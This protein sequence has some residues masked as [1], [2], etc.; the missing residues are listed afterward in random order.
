MKYQ[1]KLPVSGR[2][3][4]ETII[5]SPIGYKNREIEIYLPPNYCCLKDRYKVCFITNSGK[6]VYGPFGNGDIFDFS[7]ISDKKIKVKAILNKEYNIQIR[8]R[9][10]TVI[11]ANGELSPFEITYDYTGLID[12][13]ACK[14]A[15]S[16]CAFSDEQSL[17]KRASLIMEQVL[18]AVI[19]QIVSQ[20]Q[21]S[22]GG[23]SSQLLYNLETVVACAVSNTFNEAC[24]NYLIWCRPV[25]CLKLQNTNMVQILDKMNISIQIER[26]RQQQLFDSNLKIK[27]ITAKSIYT[28]ETEKIRAISQIGMTGA[29]SVSDLLRLL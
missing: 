12:I 9:I 3:I 11:N 8:D 27:E 19:T 13:D 5:D 29:H 20:N 24:N 22:A 25:G 14:F 1:I 18:R 21:S 28:L 2:P 4:E 10:D 7:K 16:T 23:V 6:Y 17:I 26:I 15:M